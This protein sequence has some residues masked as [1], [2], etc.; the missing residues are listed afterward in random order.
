MNEK[1]E[2]PFFNE[3]NWELIEDQLSLACKEETDLKVAVLS[4]LKESGEV[5]D[6]ISGLYDSLLSNLIRMVGHSKEQTMESFR[7]AFKS[8]KFLDR[9]IQ[10]NDSIPDE[11]QK[12]IQ[13]KGALELNRI[14]A[15]KTA[16]STERLLQRETQAIHAISSQIGELLLGII[17]NG[18]SS[19]KRAILKKSIEEAELL[20]VVIGNSS[21]PKPE[22]VLPSKGTQNALSVSFSPSVPLVAFEKSGTLMNICLESGEVRFKKRLALSSGENVLLSYSPI[23]VLLVAASRKKSVFLFNEKGE[24]IYELKNTYEETGY[25]IVTVGWL[26]LEDFYIGYANGLIKKFSGIKKKEEAAMKVDSVA[27]SKITVYDQNTLLIGFHNGYLTHYDHTKQ[28]SLFS[29]PW[30]FRRLFDG[31]FSFIFASEKN[32]LVVSGSKRTMKLLDMKSVTMKWKIK[33]RDP[34]IDATFLLG[35][36]LE[37]VALSQS[38]YIHE[39]NIETGNITKSRKVSSQ[40]MLGLKFYESKGKCF[41]VDA[42]GGFNVLAF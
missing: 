32:Q 40:K 3:V 7:S 8:A 26:N 5:V 11:L 27:P 18:A 41:L 24:G 36:K 1:N 38:D 2:N 16:L 9:T 13:N 28:Q 20:P 15:I 37:I 39:V 25:R 30:H 31:S 29:L 21:E 42:Q 19:S 34:V 17:N 23:G 10:S 6:L 33:M 22:V 12:L 4:S 14:Q 35:S